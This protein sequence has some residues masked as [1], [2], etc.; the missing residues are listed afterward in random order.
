MCQDVKKTSTSKEIPVPNSYPLW[1]IVTAFMEFWPLRFC[2][3]VY[4]TFSCWNEHTRLKA[5]TTRCR[6][7]KITFDLVY[8]ILFIRKLNLIHP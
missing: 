3:T 8:V 2:Y 4:S 7:T 1:K 5:I 6:I